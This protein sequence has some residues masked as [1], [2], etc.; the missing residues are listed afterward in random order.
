MRPI[1]VTGA[2]GQLGSELCRQ[3]GGGAV[4]LDL[5]QLDLTDRR[6]VLERLDEIQPRAVINTA[7]YTRVDQAER[8]PGLCRAVNAGAVFHLAEACR[9]VGAVLV[10]I[11]TDYVFGGDA[12]RGTPYTEED[13][14]SPQGV[15]AATKL[16]GERAAASWERHF[17]VRT[18]GLYGKPGPRSPGNFVE[19]MLRLAGERDRL[20]VVDDQHCTP[21]YV[22]HITQAIRFLL[23]TDE[24]GIYHVVNSGKTTWYRFALAIFRVARIRLRVVAITTAD[25]GLPAPRPL[26]SVLD[27]AKYHGL[28]GCPALAGWEDALVEYLAA[29][30]SR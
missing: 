30:G 2:L 16:E 9:R 18:C 22:V 20:K 24:Y 15:Y 8:E 25:Y 12:R 3:I 7:A 5:H 11:S 19:T 13:P 14:P 17:V 27:T 1:L 21:S 4:G 29:R 6:M 28:P 23:S 10:E 26:Y